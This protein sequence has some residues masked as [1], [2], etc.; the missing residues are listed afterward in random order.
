MSDIWDDPDLRPDGDYVK[1]EEPG[2]SVTGD[3]IG[4]GKHTFPDG[5]VCAKL[6]IRTDEGEDKTLTAGQV[7]LVAELRE[8]RP[9]IGDRIRVVFT[10]V[11]KRPGG[12]TMKHFTVDVK[13]GEAKNTPAAEA[14]VETDF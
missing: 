1:F 6:T 8:K 3:V 4:V 13:R 2:D 12:K 9:T 14:A 7:R 10:E 5:K 11:E